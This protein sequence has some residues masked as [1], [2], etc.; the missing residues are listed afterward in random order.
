MRRLFRALQRVRRRWIP[1][2]ALR[3]IPFVAGL[4]NHLTRMSRSPQVDVVH[5]HRMYVGKKDNLKLSLY[6]VY[7][8]CETRFF[9]NHVKTGDTVVDIGANIGYYTLLFAKRVGPS[10]R[11]YSFEPEPTNFAVLTENVRM[12]RYGNVTLVNKAVS[13]DSGIIKLF[14]SEDNEAGHSTAVSVAARAVDVES[15][16]IDEYLA[17]LDRV[18]FVKMD[19]EGG[20]CHAIKGMTAFLR[21]H[22]DVVIVMEFWP[23]GLV[24]AGIEPR[25]PL[26]LLRAMEFHIYCLNDERE[27]LEK[28]DVMTLLREFTPANE[29]H[30]NLVFCRSERWLETRLTST[31]V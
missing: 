15:V 24:N 22:P 19:I 25:T 7:E 13:N 29:R 11:V 28:A 30:C 31:N 14:I 18:D 20:E 5:G 4:A 10:G 9:E 6:G 2:V 8:E 26:D 23:K 16:R 3:R 27:K 21:R 17:Q 1:R 12:N